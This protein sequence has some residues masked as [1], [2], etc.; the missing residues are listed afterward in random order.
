M[1]I[2]NAKS[3]ILDKFGISKSNFLGSGME[4]EVYAYDD[5]K[6]VK[7]YNDMS[8]SNK[9]RILKGFYSKI[10]S[11]S[12]SYELP[13]IYDTFEE[14]GILVTI[15]KR[16][17]GNNL[18]SMLSKMNY[19]E[20]NNMMETYLNAN[21]ELKS[22]KI[23]P[24]LEGY[25]LFNDQQI[26]S[27]NINSWFD[28]LKEEIFR[29]RKELESYLKRDV[30]NYDA[31]VKQLVEILSLGYEG[32]YSLI[33]GDFYPGNVMIN[34][35]GKVT[36]LIDFGLMTMYGDNLFDIAIGWVCFDMYNELNTNIY[37]RYLNII[38]STLGEDVRKRLYFYVLIYSYISANFYSHNCE[39]GHYQWCVRNLNNKNYWEVL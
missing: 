15:E 10:D 26:S 17:E 33:H 24:N 19:I 25:I 14:N 38:I 2:F 22:V 6:V 1:T 32:E 8:D 16:I 12:L 20:Q 3:I 23:K 36:G 31:K 34:E 29:K 35:S 30:V 18:Q 39:D 28:L 13:F 4:S 11:S 7:L 37:E 9:Q 21:I 5:N 27:L